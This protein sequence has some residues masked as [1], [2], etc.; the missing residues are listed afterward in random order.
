MDRPGV[1]FLVAITYVLLK[2]VASET[3]FKRVA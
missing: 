2:N 3:S 1:D